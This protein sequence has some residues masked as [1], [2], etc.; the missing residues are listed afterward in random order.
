M[1]YYKSDTITIT[2]KVWDEYV[3]TRDI[4]L[5]NEILVSYLYIVTCS[6]KKMSSLVFSNED[7]EDM[8]N[9]GILELI[10]CI[11]R[12]DPKRGIQ[13][14]TFASIRVRGSII[15]YIRK[16]DWVPRDVRKRV[17]DLN[18]TD[19]LLH[20][21]YGRPPTDKEIAEHLNIS[22]DDVNK[23][24]KDQVSLNV[25]GFEELLQD[26]NEHL[27]NT[28][29]PSAYKQP[30]DKAL[31]DDFKTNLAKYIDELDEK[32]RTVISLYY[33]ENL[34]LKEIAFVM[35]LT[36]SRISQIHSKALTKLKGKI[37]DYLYN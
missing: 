6:I 25:M 18:D 26:N 15:D 31:E 22:M 30:E 23:V 27:F 33:Y 34:K 2:D 36:P 19:I 5:R 35:D 37:E 17:K 3:T 16:K 9:Q 12:Y 20:N 10:N 32:E 28:R 14:D 8:T 11:D 1:N 4:A 24:R 7:F 21:K 29:N 13:F